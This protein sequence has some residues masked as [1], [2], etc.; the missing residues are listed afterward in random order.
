VSS[1]VRYRIDPSASRLSIKVSTGGPLAAFGH[2]PTLVMRDVRGDLELDPDNLATASLRLVVNPDALALGNEV[3]ESDRREIERKAR[4]EVLMTSTHKEITFEC[5]AGQVV[6]NAPM[7]LSLNGELTLHGVMRPQLVSARLFVT[8]DTVRA[9]GEA[10]V[11]QSEYGIRPVTAAGGMLKVKDEVKLTFDIVA[12]KA[13]SQGETRDE[14]SSA[15]GTRS[16]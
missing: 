2:D 16:S 4:E 13:A 1:V 7:Q 5:R 11:R 12:R 8:G 10:T 15:V 6:A 14:S 3:N 9:Q